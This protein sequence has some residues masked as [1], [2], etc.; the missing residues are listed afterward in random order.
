MDEERGEKKMQMKEVQKSS[1]RI[2]IN[3]IVKGTL[4]L[5]QVQEFKKLVT[6]DDCISNRL[7]RSQGQRYNKLPGFNVDPNI[8][9]FDHNRLQLR[10]TINGCDYINCSWISQD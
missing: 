1:R 4:V 7:T 2:S 8:L 6:F 3:E 10:N 5:P 9:P